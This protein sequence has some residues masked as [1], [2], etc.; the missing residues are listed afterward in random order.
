M[1]KER[2][3]ALQWFV[4][5][6]N[7]NLTELKPG[8]KAK[9][10]IEAEDY[11]FPTKEI[12]KIPF[13]P[14]RGT[15]DTTAFFPSNK[16]IEQYIKSELK[17]MSWVSKV[18]QSRLQRGS[19]EYWTKIH[20]LQDVMK[21]VLQLPGFFLDSKGERELGGSRTLMWAGQL[22]ISMESTP[23]KFNLSYIL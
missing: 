9:F 14:S 15:K 4:S 10:L 20:H 1:E 7:L 23:E 8:D 13:L 19:N 5:F 21:D 6:T 16:N 12:E 17:G 3:E 18:S 22:M 11:L 2:E